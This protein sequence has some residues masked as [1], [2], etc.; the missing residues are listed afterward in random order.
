MNDIVK[1]KYRNVV[2]ITNK[3][4]LPSGVV[5]S[6]SKTTR[7]SFAQ[8][9]AAR[10]RK[11][12][13][14]AKYTTPLE[15][16]EVKTNSKSYDN[17]LA[18]RRI[19]ALTYVYGSVA[20]RS[21]KTESGDGSI[22][23][24]RARAKVSDFNFGESLVEFNDTTRLLGKSLTN[25]ASL[26]RDLRKGNWKG[27]E[28][29]GL[30]ISKDLKSITNGSKRVANGYLEIQF[31]WRPILSDIH[32]AIEA[33]GRTVRTVGDKIHT[34]SGQTRPPRKS[35]QREFFDPSVP[36]EASASFN[37][38]VSNPALHELNRLGLANPLLMAWNKLPLSFLADW[39]LPISPILGSLTAGLG[40]E[41]EHGA[42]VIRSMDSLVQ[43]RA[44]GQIATQYYT[45][46][47]APSSSI[48][49]TPLDSKGMS[50]RVGQIATLVALARQLIQ[51]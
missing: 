12:P 49:G 1:V 20:V 14:P 32:S 48:I 46:R 5:A 17:E 21:I 8:T 3:Y 39:L 29:R 37:G 43:E 15:F 36:L 19:G 7:T 22:Q 2:E 9:T 31:G 27:L 30:N 18:Y 45:A 13:I 11:K 44:P 24:A 28:K 26:F 10:H 25:L 35:D 50:I 40:L 38:R 33:Y 41:D 6:E 47:R 34:R 4:I 51:K 42:R 23:M 16:Y